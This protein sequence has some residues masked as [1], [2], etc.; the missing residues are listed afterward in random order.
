MPEK[1]SPAIDVFLCDC[2]GEIARTIDFGKLKETVSNLD[3][4]KSIKLHTF[5][6]GDAGRNELKAVARNGTNRV[7]IAACSP[8]L[9]EPLFRQC[10]KDVGFNPYLLEMANI[11][12]QV[13]WPHA[14]NPLG[15]TDK[16]Q[17]VVAAAVGKA[18]NIEPIEERKFEMVKSVLVIGAGVA[19]L[20]AAIGIADFGHK[21]NLIERAP[22]IGGNALKLGL[23]F[24]LTTEPFVFLRPV[25]CRVLGSVFTEPIF[26]SI[27]ILRFRRCLRLKWF[28]GRMAILK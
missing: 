14:D 3:C 28:K 25:P 6:C 18:R 22:V 13:A 20:Q 27:R 26:C 4:V 16:A 10:L 8:K 1:T 23:A 11:R 19:G 5:L 2:G 12:E 21:V 17:R 9:Y 7:V 24:P 15:A